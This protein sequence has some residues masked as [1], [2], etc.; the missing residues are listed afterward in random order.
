ML[1]F[2]IMDEKDFEIARVVVKHLLTRSSSQVGELTVD[3][4]AEQLNISRGSLYLA[5]QDPSV[6]AP[7]ELLRI[8]RIAWA[9][10]LLEEE[11][12]MPVQKISQKI[13]FNTTDHFIRVFKYY[14]MNTPLKYRKCMQKKESRNSFLPLPKKI[15]GMPEKDVRI[16]LLLVKKLWEIR[17]LVLFRMYDRLNTFFEQTD[18]I[19]GSL[20]HEMEKGPDK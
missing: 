18:S 4:L 8:I 14:F 16:L 3:K 20:I 13:G 2:Y 7:G 12:G 17:Y 6:M 9:A 19:D 5:F 11:Q 15:P 10:V 1:P